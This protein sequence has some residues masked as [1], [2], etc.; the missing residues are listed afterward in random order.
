MEDNHNEIERWV[1]DRLATL[2]ELEN[3]QPNTTRA[4]EALTARSDGRPNRHRP[5]IFAVTAAAVI[6]CTLLAF[7]IT[8]VFA[9]RC[10]DAVWMRPRVL[11]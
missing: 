4:F 2:T 3:W 6:Y 1:D 5:W 10:V 7:P 9:E 11:Q 8:R